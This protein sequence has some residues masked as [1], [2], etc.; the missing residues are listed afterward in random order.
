MEYHQDIFDDFSVLIFKENKLVALLPANKVNDKVYSHQG[1]TYGGFILPESINAFDVYTIINEVIQYY[2]ANQ[3]K[4][5]I[6]KLIPS[7]YHKKA[8]NEVSYFLQKNGAE[9]VDKKLVL[10][11]D[12]ANEL[13]IHKTKLKHK[14][15][16]KD[17]FIVEI[18]DDFSEFWNDVLIP[19]LQNKYNAKPVHSL[20]EISR[21]KTSFPE[22][23]IQYNVI[24][25]GEVVAG[26]TLFE[27]EFVVKSQYAATTD[28]GEKLR[29]LDFL[30]IQLIENY[31][32]RGKQF[33]SMGTVDSDDEIGFNKGMLKQKEELGCSCFTQEIYKLTLLHD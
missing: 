27:S 11:V 22:N 6:F 30:F 10:S 2:K 8:A 14:K 26:I 28:L 1:L 13:Q 23:I 25:E 12:Y 18:T 15:K 24:Y 31:K 19:K 20:E 16:S 4:E 29:A 7:I 32:K 9:L 21:L 17:K 5:L 3:I 33:F